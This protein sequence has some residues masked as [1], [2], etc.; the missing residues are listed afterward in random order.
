MRG[1]EGTPFPEMTAERVA[2]I[3]L[4]AL[5]KGRAVVVA[6]GLDRLWIAMTRFLPRSVPL[7]LAAAFFA[8]TRV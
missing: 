4:D 2:E 5:G 8:K 6:H 1:A 7:R 3:G